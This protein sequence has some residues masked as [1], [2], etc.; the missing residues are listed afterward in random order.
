MDKKQRKSLS[1]NNSSSQTRTT[2]S[3]SESTTTFT[4]PEFSAFLDVMF[5]EGKKRFTE[6]LKTEEW[7]AI[8]E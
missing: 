7:R 8:Y 2:H 3:K 6:Y 1:D 4:Q 5:A